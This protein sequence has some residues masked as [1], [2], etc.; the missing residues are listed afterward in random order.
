M[1]KILQQLQS[2]P[3]AIRMMFAGLLAL[4]T[5]GFIFA[6]WVMVP[7]EKQERVKTDQVPSPL[8]A[9][10][11]S[12]RTTIQ[13]SPLVNRDSEKNVEIINATELESS[14]PEIINQSDQ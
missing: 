13:D 2:K 8:S 7:S 6:G 4:I 1:K 5:T 10:G 9:L 3:P 12:I 11:Q 14:L